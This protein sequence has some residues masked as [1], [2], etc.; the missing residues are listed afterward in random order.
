MLSVTGSIPA[1]EFIVVG[2]DL[3]GH[4]GTN[5]VGYDGVHGGYGFRERNAYGQRLLEFCDAMELVV[6]NTSS[7]G[8]RINWPPMYMLAQ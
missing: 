7:R 4:V 8:R 2:G 3:N 5:V 6:A 1:S